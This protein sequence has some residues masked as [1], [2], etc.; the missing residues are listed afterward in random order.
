MRQMLRSRYPFHTVFWLGIHGF[1]YGTAARVAV[2]DFLFR[3]LPLLQ[4]LGFFGQSMLGVILQ[5]HLGL[6]SPSEIL[7]V[8]FRRWALG[9]GSPGEM[10]FLEG[11]L[12]S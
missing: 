6:R 5:L 2:S 7:F 8:C 10:R 3:A 4:C 1:A 9:Y 11:R 12:Q